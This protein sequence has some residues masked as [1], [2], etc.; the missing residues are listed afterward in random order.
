MDITPLV[1]SD[2]SIIQSY[3]EEGVMVAGVLYTSPILVFPDIVEKWP[4]KDISSLSYDNFLSVFERGDIELVL[5]GGG[6]ETSLLPAKIKTRIR[7]HGIVVEAMT[8]A[9]ACRTHNILL[10]EDR[11]FVSALFPLLGDY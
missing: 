8:T 7:D 11:R 3:S 6:I 5:L 10:T 9:A 2:A 1:S 4:V